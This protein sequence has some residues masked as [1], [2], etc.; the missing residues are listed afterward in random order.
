MHDGSI[1]TLAAVID[2]Y[3][4][5]GRN[6]ESGT[7]QGDGRLNPGKSTFIRGFVLT[8]DEKEDLLNFLHSLT[9]QKF[10]TNVAFAAP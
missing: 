7:Y 2:F 1:A 8:A 6:V 10:L 9:D 4:A 5:G 3:S